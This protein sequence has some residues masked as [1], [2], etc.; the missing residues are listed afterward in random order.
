MIKSLTIKE[1]RISTAFD[2]Y[3]FFYIIFFFRSKRR[4]KDRTGVLKKTYG[5]TSINYR[6]QNKQRLIYIFLKYL[7]SLYVKHNKRSILL[8]NVKQKYISTVQCSNLYQH[9]TVRTDTLLGQ[10]VC[11]C[12]RLRL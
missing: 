4:R 11:S 8:V 10:Y 7:L 1:R 6:L 5:C 12:I 9:N 2:V 3:N